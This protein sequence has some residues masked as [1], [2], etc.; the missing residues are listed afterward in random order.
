MATTSGASLD[1]AYMTTKVADGWYK[2]MSAGRD[3]TGTAIHI[4]A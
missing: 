1:D 4:A 2:G 3:A